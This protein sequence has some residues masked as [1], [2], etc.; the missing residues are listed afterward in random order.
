M[1]QIK[2]RQVAAHE[3]RCLMAGS[4][5]TS[6]RDPSASTLR[7]AERHSCRIGTRCYRETI[8]RRTGSRDKGFSTIR[9]FEK[10]FRGREKNRFNLHARVNE[11]WNSYTFNAPLN[12][13]RVRYSWCFT[14]QSH[15]INRGR[16]FKAINFIIRST[17][18][19]IPRSHYFPWI[20]V[21]FFCKYTLWYIYTGTERKKPWIFATL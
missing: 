13:T 19:I 3:W 9:L 12:S 10:S 14:W 7:W 15:G 17:H 6:H 4:S 8:I 2:D 1:P 21:S 18:S 11:Q 20:R 5:F 16:D